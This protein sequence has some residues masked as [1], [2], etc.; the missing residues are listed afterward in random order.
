MAARAPVSRSCRCL[1][2]L[3]LPA[4]RS[5]ATAASRR[6]SPPRRTPRG[7]TTATSG[8]RSSPA[9]SSCSSRARCSG[10]SSATAA[11]GAPAPRTAPRSTATRTWSSRG[12]SRRCWSSSR[13]APSSSA[14]CPGSRTCPPRTRQGGRVDVQVK[15]YRYYW[16]FTYPNGVIAVDKLRAPVGQNVR[17]EVTGS[18]LRRDPLLVDPRARRQVRRDSGRDERDVVQRDRAWDLPRPVRRALRHPARGDEGR[19]R[20]DAA[21]GVRGVAGR[22][23]SALRRRAPPASARRRSRGACAKCHG[24]AGEGDIGP[25]LAGNAAARRRKR[26]RAGRARTAEERCRRSARTGTTGRWTR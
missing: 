11:G 7:S 20:G 3:A 23:G 12:R 16:N 9:R 14:S 26:D 15:G 8:S 10:S 24:L 17:L 4:S 19:G 25:A 18:G 2:A 6:S 21:R 5:R 22:G 13:S 1:S